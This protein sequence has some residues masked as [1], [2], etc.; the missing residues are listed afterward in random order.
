[1]VSIRYPPVCSSSRV[2]P[3]LALASATT[4]S[5]RYP[6]WPVRSTWVAAFVHHR[7]PRRDRSCVAWSGSSQPSSVIA[8]ST[9]FQR[10]VAAALPPSHGS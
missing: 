6:R 7:Q 1:M 5:S 8:T 3:Y 10:T 9:D 4:I 2:S